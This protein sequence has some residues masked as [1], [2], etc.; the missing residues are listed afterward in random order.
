DLVHIDGNHDAETV[1]KDV[2]NYLP[3]LKDN[4]VLIMDDVSWDSVKPAYQEVS[5][6][7]PRVFEAHEQTDYAV[8]LNSRSK[9][10]IISSMIALNRI[11]RR[12]EAAQIR[13][14]IFRQARRALIIM[15]GIVFAHPGPYDG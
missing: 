3:R 10:K 7:M 14:S 12:L 8:F 6:K 13:S 5:A 2:R 4:A 11:G 9:I 15:N 1:M